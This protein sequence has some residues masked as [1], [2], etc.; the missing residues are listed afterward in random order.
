MSLKVNQNEAQWKTIKAP[1]F[2]CSLFTRGILNARKQDEHH[3]PVY[4]AQGT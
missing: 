1:N 4:P 3:G 2:V